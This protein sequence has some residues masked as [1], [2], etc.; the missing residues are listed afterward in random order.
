LYSRM[1]GTFGLRDIS[2]VVR[3]VLLG[4]LLA[5]LIIA[6]VYRFQ[7][8][9]RGVFVIDAA[10][11]LLAVFGSRASF[12]LFETAAWTRRES[13]R[14]ILVYGAGRRGQLLVREML[15]N[16]DWHMVPAGFLDDAPYMTH[17]RLIGV[18]VRGGLAD[19]DRV[20]GKV[21]VD[22]VV[23]STVAVDAE[24]ETRIRVI[25]GQREVGVKRLFLEIR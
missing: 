2:T 25:C 5:V 11:F 17:R 20:L 8:F 15:A 13:N 21:R 18:P 14:R 7:G 4:S 10:L 23:I 19:L 24:M 1:W 6:Y 16:P 12:R 22:E 9:S 3:G